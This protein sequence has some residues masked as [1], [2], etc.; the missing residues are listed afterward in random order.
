VF[1]FASSLFAQSKRTVRI[2]F[3]D[4]PAN[5][6]EKI[7]LHAS[8]DPALAGAAQEVELPRMNLSPPYILPSGDITVSLAPQALPVDQPVAA[9][10]PKTTIPAAINDLYLLVTHDPANKLV[11]LSMQVISANPDSFKKGQMMWYNLTNH[12]VGG[13]LGSQKLDMKPQSRAILDAPATGMEDY[14]VSLRYYRAGQEKLF[15][16]CETTWSHDS[17]SRSVYFIINQSDSPAPRVMGFSDYRE[18]EKKEE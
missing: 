18:P 10:N 6:P 7:Y 17:R 15:P 1:T 9:A 5:A 12:R 13:Q 2:L 4:G 16:L 11:P 3:L 8:A 14:V